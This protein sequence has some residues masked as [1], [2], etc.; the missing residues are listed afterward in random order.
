MILQES[1]P[2]SNIEYSKILDET[3]RPANH[4]MRGAND[5]GNVSDLLISAMSHLRPKLF[6]WFF[7]KH[8]QGR[9]L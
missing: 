5:R 9:C 6:S 2:V 3:H 1:N 7:C 8:L 4:F